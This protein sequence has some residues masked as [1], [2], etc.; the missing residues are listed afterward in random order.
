MREHT[1]EVIARAIVTDDTKTK[2]LFCAPKDTS[3][4]YLPGGHVEFG[5]TA[6][7]AL[8]RELYEETGV[9]TGT[10]EFHFAGTAENIFMQENAPHHE[11]N[12]YFEM[13]GAV[14]G[15]GE[16]ISLEEDISFHWLALTDIPN[17]HVLPEEAKSFLSEWT[18]SFSGKKI[19]WET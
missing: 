12:L 17:L 18:S 5:E 16:V 7:V 2:M 19:S 11:I 4:F 14:F 15:N 8:A 9:D 10:A 13:G 6:K 3:Y 1:I